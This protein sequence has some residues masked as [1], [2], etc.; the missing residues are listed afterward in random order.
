MRNTLAVDELQ[1]R[2]QVLDDQAGLVLGELNALLD[3]VQQR[4]AIDLLE[5]QEEA[6]LLLE[7]LD[8]LDDVLVALTVVEQLDLLEDTRTTQA[9][10]LDDR[11]NGVLLAGLLVDAALNFGISTLAKYLSGQFIEIVEA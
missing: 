5:D 8:Q 10:M 1:C 6:I 3:V 9:G 7:E 4:A 11:L 2:S